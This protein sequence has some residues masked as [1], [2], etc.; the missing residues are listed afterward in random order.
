M[1][2]ILSWI[3]Y[4]MMLINFFLFAFRVQYNKNSAYRIFTIYIAII[5]IIQVATYILRCYTIHNLFLS[6]FYFVLQ[7]ITLSFFYNTLL[8]EKLQKKIVKMGLI[9]GLLAL[10][11]QYAMQPELFFKFNLFEIFITSFLLII[12]STFHFYNLLNEKKYFYYI[13]AGILVYLFGSTVLFLAGNLVSSLASKMNT[14]TWTL[15]AFLYIIYQ[16][17]IFVEWKKSFSRTE[18]NKAVL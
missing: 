13:N 3:G 11:I 7:F 9:L 1:D 10:T 14:V 12:F 5:S 4:V 16:V 8:K 17:F 6:H 18:A 15:N 2:E